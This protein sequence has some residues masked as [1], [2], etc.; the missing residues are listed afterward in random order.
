MID[1]FISSQPTIRPNKLDTVSSEQAD[2]SENYNQFPVGLVTE[3]LASI[4]ETQGKTEKAIS[5][6]EELIL[7]NPEKKSYFASRIKNL[8]KK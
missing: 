3:N 1:E 8:K 6:Y 2:L 5:I 4:F 7:K